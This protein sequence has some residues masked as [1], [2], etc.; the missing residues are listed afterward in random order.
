MDQ[1]ISVKIAGRMFNLTASSPEAEQ[2]Y[3]EA[4]ETINRR[5]AAYTRSHPGKNVSDL[6]SMI[7]LNE[8]VI[9]LELQQEIDQYKEDKDLLARDLERY[10][11][12]N[13]KK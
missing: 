7:A 5:F 10:L 8:T 6:L 2:L 13:G 4:A 11:Q 12:D 3:R 9:R 1:K